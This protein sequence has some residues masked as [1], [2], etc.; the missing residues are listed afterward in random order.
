MVTI[1]FFLPA[2]TTAAAKLWKRRVG[3]N[4]FAVNI[5]Q[6]ARG[7]EKLGKKILWV[8][9]FIFFQVINAKPLEI[10]FFHLCYI[11]LGLGKL[12]YLPN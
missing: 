6:R 2:G 10:V 9:N 11:L 1:L 4:F 5:L 8:Y 7:R 12:S 3:G